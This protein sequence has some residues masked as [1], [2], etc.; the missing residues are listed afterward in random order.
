MSLPSHL[1]GFQRS[2]SCHGLS[3]SG[4]G[5]RGHWIHGKWIPC[6]LDP[7]VVRPST[8]CSSLPMRL[9]VLDPE[10]QGSSMTTPKHNRGRLEAQKRRATAA[11]PPDGRSPAPPLVLVLVCVQAR[12]SVSATAGVTCSSAHGVEK[13]IPRD[14]TVLCGILVLDWLGLPMSSTLVR[15]RDPLGLTVVSH[16]SS[17]LFPT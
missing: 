15:R 3:C 5:R 1:A 11:P 14:T 8:P 4:F 2:P 12:L 9:A 16:C 17:L 6:V 7:A 10:L 13:Y